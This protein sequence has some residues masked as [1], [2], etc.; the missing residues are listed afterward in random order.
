MKLYFDS[1]DIFGILKGIQCPPL[2]LATMA[3][4]QVNATLSSQNYLYLSN[5][6]LSINMYIICYL[7]VVTLYRKNIF[8]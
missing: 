7:R 6:Q 1:K 4:V 5:G 2:G 8:S 3:V